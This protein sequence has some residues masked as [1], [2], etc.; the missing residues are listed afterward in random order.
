MFSHFI[1]A[2]EV[3]GGGG[4]VALLGGVHGGE[5]QG[6]SQLIKNSEIN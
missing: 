2:L 1:E 4:V 6:V 3:M 5:R